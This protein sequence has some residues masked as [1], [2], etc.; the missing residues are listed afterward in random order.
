MLLV[1]LLD[2]RQV[3]DAVAHLVVVTVLTCA[4]ITVTHTVTAIQVADVRLT[5]CSMHTPPVSLIVST[6]GIRRIIFLHD[7][8]NVIFTGTGSEERSVKREE[9]C[10]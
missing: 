9:R 2:N 3:D 1:E 8:L 10:T 5:L 7:R 4:V 6:V